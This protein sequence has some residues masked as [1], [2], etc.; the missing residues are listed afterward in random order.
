MLEHFS[1]IGW[2][3]VIDIL[4]VGFVIY[5]LILIIRGTRSAQII[6]GIGI[7]SGI[8]FLSGLLDLP[9]MKWLMKTFLSSIV[10]IL[11]IVFQNDIRRA[12]LRVGQS[13]FHKREDV[14]ERTVNEIG[15][16][17][18]Y[19]AHRKIGALVVLEQESSL[20]E[21][22]DS[23]S[24][25]D[26]RL[27]KELLISIFIPS[28][29]LHDGAVIV[30]GGRIQHA[31]CIL[32]LTQNPYI[33]RKY[34]TRHRAALGLSEESDAIVLV[35]SEERKEVSVVQQGRLTLIE[36]EIHFS[37]VLKELFAESSSLGWK[38]LIG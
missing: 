35:V 12:L 30:S 8:Y 34:G 31:G 11:I 2:R 5:Q 33:N 27:S 32:P 23:G 26:A 21:F 18:F 13:P 17:L 14:A 10:L 24:E 25:L 1:Y 6:I 15:A 38:N 29:P 20:D 22:I 37:K 4:L 19:L 7:L 28:S 16:T 9:T 36:D 3:D